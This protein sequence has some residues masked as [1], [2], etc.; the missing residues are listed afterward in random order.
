MF[1]PMLIFNVLLILSE[2]APWQQKK[3]PTKCR[4]GREGTQMEDAKRDI[5]KYN[6]LELIIIAKLVEEF[7]MNCPDE[8][9]TIF[10]HCDV[11]ND[12]IF[13]VDEFHCGLNGLF[14]FVD[15]D[16]DKCIETKETSA[17]LAKCGKQLKAANIE[18]Q[19]GQIFAKSAFLS[20]KKSCNCGVVVVKTLR[21]GVK[22]LVLGGRQDQRIRFLVGKIK[23]TDPSNSPGK[24]EK[25]NN[26][27]EYSDVDWSDMLHIE[28]FLCTCHNALNQFGR[29]YN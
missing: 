16:A 12:K 1:Y 8:I 25:V 22:V 7:A 6:G 2:G 5:L 17:F 9:M 3:K 10:E 15:A 26:F 11:G 24:Y 20:V 28:Y 27:A 29:I 13:T 4:D 19:I 14:D 18:D 23:G 21:D